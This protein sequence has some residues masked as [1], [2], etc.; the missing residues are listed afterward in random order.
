MRAKGLILVLLLSSRAYASCPVFLRKLSNFFENHKYERI[1]KKK[2]RFFDELRRFQSRKNASTY[3]INK[4]SK[5]F[6]KFLTVDK[7]LTTHQ[8][9]LVDLYWNEIHNPV[10]LESFAKGLFLEV[11]KKMNQS[12]KPKHKILLYEKNRLDREV[13]FEVLVARLVNSEVGFVGTETITR[14]FS[15]KEFSEVLSRKKLVIDK[16]FAGMIH[17]EYVHIYQ[18]AYLLH[19]AK[20]NGLP[21][22]IV[23]SFYEWISNIER[24]DITK[25]VSFCPAHDGWVAMFDSIEGDL[26]NP[27]NL[28]PLLES[29]FF[30]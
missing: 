15:P 16:N 11:A 7:T 4:R 23:S 28:N 12:A 29:L 22:N 18:M 19:L 10:H 3:K 1:M 21:Q 6:I 30:Y 8:R 5:R 9:E 2:V 13:L 26:T 14:T 25:D 24:Y 20:V 17:G 27:Q